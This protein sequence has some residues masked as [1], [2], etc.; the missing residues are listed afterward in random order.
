LGTP[1]TGVEELG[2]ISQIELQNR[3]GNINASVRP[4]PTS[5]GQ[6]YVSIALIAPDGS[7]AAMSPYQ[8]LRPL[9]DAG[10]AYTD[11]STKN[12]AAVLPV[13]PLLKFYHAF[14]IVDGIVLHFIDEHH[15]TSE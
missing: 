11:K 4:I 12:R 8:I 15:L 7:S 3:L 5:I 14:R 1:V 2:P 6:E 10:L 13:N 9:I